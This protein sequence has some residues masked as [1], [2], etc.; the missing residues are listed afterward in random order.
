[1]ELWGSERRPH[2]QERQSQIVRGLL[3]D[4]RAYLVGE[5]RPRPADHGEHIHVRFGSVIRMMS[6]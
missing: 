1:M 4:A 6:G 2:E 5:P 3:C